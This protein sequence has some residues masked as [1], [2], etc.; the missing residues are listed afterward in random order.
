MEEETFLRLLNSQTQALTQVA[1]ISNE[2]N[3]VLKKVVD[4]Q[5]QQT[6]LISAVLDATAQFRSDTFRLLVGVIIFLVVVI[7]GLLVKLNV[8][9]GDVIHQVGKSAYNQVM[10][11][12]LMDVEPND[13]G[14]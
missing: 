5:A 13:A 10:P 2:T 8:K 6:Q 4:N 9:G 14:K 1:L 11:S 3:G 12:T 7:G